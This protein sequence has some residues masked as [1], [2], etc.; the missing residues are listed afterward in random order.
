[1]K[2]PQREH[3]RR[4]RKGKTFKAGRGNSDALFAS[5][6][7]GWKKVP[8]RFRTS[9]IRVIARYERKK[10]REAIEFH[11]SSRSEY[12]YSVDY[13]C[14]NA[15]SYKPFKSEKKAKAALKQLILEVIK[16][17]KK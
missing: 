15:G 5:L 3:L 2:R 14:M 11:F 7:K 8:A 6:P 10:T 16:R 1:M 17:S 13:E 4:S 9:G 12:H